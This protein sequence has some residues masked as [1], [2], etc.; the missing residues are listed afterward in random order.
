MTV[1]QASD[2]RLF[3][4]TFLDGCLV[5]VGVSRLPAAAFAASVTAAARVSLTSRDLR[6]LDD[7]IQSVAFWR[8]RFDTNGD[9]LFDERNL[10]AFLG[11]KGALPRDDRFHFAFDF[12]GDDAAT[13]QDIQYLFDLTSRFPEGYLLDPW[14]DVSTVKTIAA[15]YPWYT[16]PASWDRARS[17]PLRGRYHSFDSSVYRQQRLEAHASGI[18]VFAVSTFNPDNTRQFHLMQEELER[19]REPEL[20]RFLWLYEILGRLPFTL[21]DIGQEIVNF[22]NPQTRAAFVAHMVELAGYFHDN[23]L[24]LDERYY[25]IWIWKTDTIRG[26]FVQAVQDARFAVRSCCGRELAMIGGELAQFP[27]ESTE[28]ERRLP[29]FLAMTHYGVYTPLFTDVY[30]GRLSVAHTDFTISN[31]LR[32]IQIVR[33]QGNNTIYQRPMT[34]W[35]P[36]QFGFDDTKGTR[37]NPPISAS[38]EELE[39]YVQQLDRRVVLPNQDVVSH[40]NHTSYNEHREGHGLEPTDGYNG[41]RSWL[42]I[43]NVYRGPSRYYRQTIVSDPELR[44]HLA[45]IFDRADDRT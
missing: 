6:T 31:L 40:L 2:R 16:K 28:L 45:A 7:Y 27:I 37:N 10:N 20:T 29:A 44:A 12:N 3:L 23:Y 1:D 4:K 30:G 21:N 43:C 36:A 32:W 8:Q 14:S 39:Y 13:N 5:A 25:P 18:D 41:V 42:Q 35:A 22:D 33:N 9:G 38:R 34:Y 11:R 19:T 26:D 24:T 15:Y 17:T